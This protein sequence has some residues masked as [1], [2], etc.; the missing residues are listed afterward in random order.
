MMSKT[1]K[2]VADELGVSKT[3]IRNKLKQSEKQFAEFAETVS[4]VIYI[5]EIGETFI[6]KA[7]IKLSEKQFAENVAETKSDMFAVL[8]QFETVIDML[9]T[10]LF[11]KNKQIAELQKLLDQ[12]Q[13]LQQQ[14][15]IPILTDKLN[16]WQ[17]FFRKG[18]H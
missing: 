12:Q 5:N 17:K 1:I 7:F 14:Q 6:K 4:G 16:L 18:V 11:E 3:A 2:Q 10:E 15:T 13:Q 8:K 9:K